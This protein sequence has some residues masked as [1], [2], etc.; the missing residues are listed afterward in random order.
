M[1]IIDI[2][3][4]RFSERVFRGGF[5]SIEMPVRAVTRTLELCSPR[6]RGSHLIMEQS[7]CKCCF[8]HDHRRGST[9]FNSIIRQKSTWSP[10]MITKEVFREI[11]RKF[12]PCTYFFDTVRAFG[13]RE[14]D[15]SNK[16]W[17]FRSQRTRGR[18]VEGQTPPFNG[19][20]PCLRN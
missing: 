1:S 10:L 3:D 12:E 5:A 6:P 16:M 17:G 8:L 11:T 18:D 13:F 14:D 15:F 2:V 4:I 20:F 7:S 9:N 19:V